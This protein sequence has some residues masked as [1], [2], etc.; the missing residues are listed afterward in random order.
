MQKNTIWNRTEKRKR[1]RK[2]KK[3]RAAADQ[4]FSQLSNEKKK[5]GQGTVIEISKRSKKAKR[6]LPGLALPSNL[7][8]QPIQSNQAQPP[9]N[10]PEK[11]N[12]H[13]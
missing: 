4:T 8:N 3:K 2:R 7:D 9:Q 6:I 12:A 1:E 13:K 11:K 10:H 5:N